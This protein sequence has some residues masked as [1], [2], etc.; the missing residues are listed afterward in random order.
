M[1]QSTYNPCKTSLPQLLYYH[2]TRDMQDLYSRFDSYSFIWN[3]D[4]EV[5]F[6]EFLCGELSANPLRATASHSSDSGPSNLR[7]IA[8]IRSQSRSYFYTI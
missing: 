3:L 8:A 2:L 6:G 1:E 5:T 4:V 7:M